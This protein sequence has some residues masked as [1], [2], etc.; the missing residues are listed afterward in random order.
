M[1]P[2]FLII[3]YQ[4]INPRLRGETGNEALYWLSSAVVP[5]VGLVVGVVA[6]DELRPP[7]AEAAK[8]KVSSFFYRLTTGI[9][10]FYLATVLAFIVLAA[11]IGGGSPKERI[12]V[13]HMAEGPLGIL[14]GLVSAAMGVFFVT[15]NKEGGAAP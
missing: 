7:T 11:Q 6:S 1:L 2:S 8:R 12:G 15:G 5:T 9:S 4:V 10:V 14:Q 13:L 3:T